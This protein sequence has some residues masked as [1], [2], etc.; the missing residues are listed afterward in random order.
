MSDDTTSS[1]CPKCTPKKTTRNELNSSKE[2]K[3]SRC[4]LCD[5]IIGTSN[6]TGYCE[7]CRACDASKEELKFSTYTKAWYCD[8]CE[9]EFDLKKTCNLCK[10]VIPIDGKT[11]LCC[12]CFL[13][14]KT[15]H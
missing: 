12:E 5:D 13:H 6:K 8:N 7:V 3:L 4:K 1:I 14:K 15:H 10:V 9:N 11:G 2:E